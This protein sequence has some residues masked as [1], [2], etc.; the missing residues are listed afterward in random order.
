M[1]GLIFT[2]ALM[3]LG[4]AGSIFSPFVGFLV[5]VAFSI[6]RPEFMWPWS[7]SQGHYSRLVTSV[8]CC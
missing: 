2:Y 5:Y 3:G 4:V 1:K 6:L 8:A 7:V